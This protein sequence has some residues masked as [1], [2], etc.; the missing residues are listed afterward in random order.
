MYVKNKLFGGII[1]GIE[2]DKDLIQ[3][4]RVYQWVTFL[5]HAYHKD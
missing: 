4:P 3:V 5:I 1:L 2:D